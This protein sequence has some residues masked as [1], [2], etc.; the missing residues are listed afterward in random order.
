MPIVAIH[1]VFHDIAVFRETAGSVPARR[2][3]VPLMRD[4]EGTLEMELRGGCVLALHHQGELYVH[5]VRI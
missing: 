3:P 2:R 5:A 1:D 4:G